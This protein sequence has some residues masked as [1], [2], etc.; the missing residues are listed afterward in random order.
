[1][2]TR[3]KLLVDRL[4]A[5]PV[6]RALAV[7]VRGAGHVL[8]LD[9]AVQPEKVRTI[10][11][12]KIVGMGSIVQ[13]LPF[14]HG[15]KREFPNARIIFL[16]GVNNRGLVDRLSCVDQALYLD[17]GNL[18]TLGT[19][20][21]SALARL[22]VGGVD[23]FFDLEVYS[24]GTSLLG[25]MSLARNRYGFYR[26]T[27]NFRKNIYTHLLSFN[28]RVPVSQLYLQ[29]LRAAVPGAQ[30][31]TEVPPLP[32]RDD[33]RAG[34]RARLQQAGQP[35]AAQ[36]VVVNPNAS[37]LLIERRWPADHVVEAVERL[38][39]MGLQV[40]L[41]G[42]RSE[43]AYVGDIARRCPPGVVDSSGRLSLGELLALLEGAACVVTNDTGP[44]H[45]AIALRRPTVCLFGPGDPDHYGTFNRTTEII[46]RG[47]ACSPCIYETD[48]PPCAGDNVCMQQITPLEV[49]DAVQRMMRGE[50]P[51]ARPHRA[52]IMMTG[53][54]GQP[55]GMLVQESAVDHPNAPAWRR[56]VRTG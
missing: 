49:V 42:A 3:Q 54:R 25:L 35:L 16:T 45:L 37:D 36:Y 8:R 38:Q 10:L 53:E 55:L 15:L 34:L 41:T 13:A 20:T 22:L 39:E 4:I 51:R 40:V 23:L 6:A 2:D 7:A 11:V 26:H 46:Y 19:D 14:L 12:A 31:P 17:D 27:A 28:I 32:V 21:A 56:R 5:T 44:M 50:P 29:L 24:G 9:H 1:M 52:S 47:V 48:V 30:V 43:A 33:E 18:L